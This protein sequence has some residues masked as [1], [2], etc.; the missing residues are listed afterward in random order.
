[1]TAVLQALVE[2]FVSEQGLSPEQLGQVAALGLTLPEFA[3][4]AATSA[5]ERGPADGQG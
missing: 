4:Y 2:A 1:M 5:L 3:V